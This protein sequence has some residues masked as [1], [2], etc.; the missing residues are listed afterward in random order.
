MSPA[1]ACFALLPLLLLPLAGCA[2]LRQV[3]VTDL[4]PG[5]YCEIEMTVPPN[6]SEDSHHKYMGWVKEVNHDEVVLTGD[7]TDQKVMEQTNIDYNGKAH[8]MT[9][10]KH[11]LVH[12][13]LAGVQEIWA[14]K[15]P[16]GSVASPAGSAAPGTAQLPAAGIQ[17]AVPSNDGAVRF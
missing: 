16:R 2:E 3:D 7:G 10:R 13:P 17:P 1:G 11:D 5:T 12:V 9:Q 14:E 8:A 6:A 15:S 4:R